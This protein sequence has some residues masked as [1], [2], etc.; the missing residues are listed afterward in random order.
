VAG[1]GLAC[2]ACGGRLIQW[3]EAT[4]SDPQLAPRSRYP[5][6]RCPRCGSAV[7][8]EA[9]S[10]DGPASLYEAGTYAPARRSLDWLIEPLRRLTDF[11][12]ERFVGAIP[13][14]A[15]VLEV[16]AGDGRFLARLAGAG[17][18]VSGIEPSAAACEQARARGVEIENVGIGDARVAPRSQDAVVLWHVLEHLDE[19]EAALRRVREWL[20]PRGRVVVACPNLGSLQA[21]IGGDAWFHQDVP[22]HRTHFTAL[23]LRLLL[24]RTGFRIERVRHLLIEQN[25]L[26]MWQTLL[27]RLTRER[28]VAFRFIKRD[29]GQ[30]GRGDRRRDLVVTAIAGPLLAPVAL[31]LELAAGLRRRGGT[32]VIEAVAA[33]ADG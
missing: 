33:D 20:V 16:G 9:R 26:G 27:N 31:G 5:L 25:P 12:R 18:R 17:H 6:A 21:R 2:P 28:D 14:G 8:V 4:A 19:P 11:D 3:R 22:R 24:E 23:G 15:R 1:R 29:L 7:T 30:A 10:G 13:P 32:M